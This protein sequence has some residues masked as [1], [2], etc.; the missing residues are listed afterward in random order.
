M[1]YKKIDADAVN[2]NEPF[3]AFV[4][5]GLGANLKETRE[6]RVRRA[7][8]AWPVDNR[9]ILSGYPHS[10]VYP[11]F[12]WP[13]SD[14]CKKITVTIR[15]TVSDASV[16]M[17]VGTLTTGTFSVPKEDHTTVETGSTSTS[18]IVNVDGL[19]SLVPIYLS[20]YSDLADDE[21]TTSVSKSD[22]QDFGLIWASNRISLP[23][24]HGITIL[25]NAGDRWIV[26]FKPNA[27][28]S[29]RIN[30]GDLYTPKQI[31]EVDDAE[32]TVWFTPRMSGA[33][34]ATVNAIVNNE[35]E[36][37]TG[38][39]LTLAFQTI[40]H[41]KVSG[42]SVHESEIYE[43]DSLQGLFYPA[44]SPV[45]GN[46]R[47]LYMHGN[48]IATT[49]TRIHHIGP[50]FDPDN[51]NSFNSG[52]GFVLSEKVISIWGEGPVPLTTG[53]DYKPMAATWAG[54]YPRNNL[55]GD[56]SR[57]R[58]R[59]RA[60]G[61]MIVVT[62]D[63]AHEG[64]NRGLLIDVRAS[65]YSWGGTE[66]DGS[67]S[68]GTEQTIPV[69]GISGYRDDETGYLVNFGDGDDHLH[70]YLR[71]GFLDS[72]VGQ[73]EIIPF[74]VYVTDAQTT[75]ADRMVRL[76]VKINDIGTVTGYVKAYCLTCTVWEEEGSYGA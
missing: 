44:R 45:S 63:G 7:S 46:V 5:Q 69:D 49:Q 75:A 53:G 16:H 76:E 66:W 68:N 26:Y 24:G 43:F 25:G 74:S 56:T 17:A 20:V 23:G 27:A 33:M 19:P 32:N 8:F 18:F 70:Q 42:I 61:L 40:G 55:N 65:V 52:V 34:F 1:A 11:L 57:Y 54:S 37:G 9:P 28:S 6:N 15:H 14:R 4:L 31:I 50:T 62:R 3:D 29:N 10:V 72:E 30:P 21:Q 48:E 36:I 13:N 47:N 60:S 2:A 71:G 39:S 38:G 22:M 51:F 58:N 59:L 73:K 64:E 12:V 35:D 67:A 41:S